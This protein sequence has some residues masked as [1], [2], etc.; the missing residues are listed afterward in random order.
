M[1]APQKGILVLKP[2]G[3]VPLCEARGLAVW[4]LECSNPKQLYEQTYAVYA[5]GKTKV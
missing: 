4:V 3:S 1:H 5:D 2:Q